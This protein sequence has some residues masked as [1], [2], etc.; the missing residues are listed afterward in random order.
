MYHYRRTVRRIC[1]PGIIVIRGRRNNLFTT[2]NSI[3]YIFL[4]I[5]S[6]ERTVQHFVQLFIPI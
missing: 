6:F 3:F 2:E 1:L 5:E 4:T